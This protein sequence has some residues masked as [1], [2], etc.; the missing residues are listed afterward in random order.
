MAHRLPS[1]LAAALVVTACAA[2]VSCG[3]PRRPAPPPPD[4]DPLLLGGGPAPAPSLPDLLA[5]YPL[6]DARARADLLAVTEEC[7]VFLLQTRDGVPPH[8]HRTHTERTR[9]LA[10]DG[11]CSIAGKDRPANAGAEFAIAPGTV[12]AVVNRGSSPLVAL[13]VFTP[14]MTSIDA[15]RVPVR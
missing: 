13:V 15:D 14:P 6:G 12:H 5:A 9:V 2:A 7:S 4:R 10:G 3:G 8:L 11:V 1:A